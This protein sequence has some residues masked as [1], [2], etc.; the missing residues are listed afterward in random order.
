MRLFF[1]ENLFL[2]TLWGPIGD[3]KNDVVIDIYFLEFLEQ[4]KRVMIFKKVIDE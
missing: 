4:R 1:T 3:Q 2:T